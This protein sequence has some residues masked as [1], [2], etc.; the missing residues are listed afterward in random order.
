MIAAPTPTPL[1]GASPPTSRA[2]PPGAP[3]GALPFQS[4]LAEHWARTATAEGHK[5]ERSHEE[6][7]EH[8]HGHERTETAPAAVPTAATF[9]AAR[10]FG[11]LA[12][13]EAPIGHAAGVPVASTVD[14]NTA[15]AGAPSRDLL[16]GAPAA[17]V[18]AAG[19]EAAPASSGQDV[20]SAIPDAGTPAADQSNDDTA[21]SLSNSATASTL[22][23]TSTSTAS[24]PTADL[25]HASR[26]SRTT[27]DTTHSKDATPPGETRPSPGDAN[28]PTGDPHEPTGDANQPTGDTRPSSGDVNQPTGDPHEPTGDVPVPSPRHEPTGD[29]S[30]TGDVSRTGEHSTGDHSAT[31][32]V[33]R[34]GDRSATGGVWQAGGGSAAGDVAQAV[35]RGVLA[36]TSARTAAAT[37]DGVLSPST[38][39][40]ASVSTHDAP[41]TPAATGDPSTPPAPGSPGASQGQTPPAAVS[42]ASP[43]AAAARPEPG[44]AGSSNVARSGD[45]LIAAVAQPEAL[46]TRTLATSTRGASTRAGALDA[47][48]AGASSRPA[49]RASGLQ[50]FT[51]PLPAT[52]TSTAAPAATLA[53]GVGM[54]DM[55][56]SIRATIEVA[57]RQGTTRARIALQ[58]EELGEIRIHLS[59][60][61]EGLLA[62]VTADT[63]AAAQALASGRAELHHS[64]SSLGVTLLRLDIGSS[65]QS[66]IGGG[67]GRFPG[68]SDESGSGPSSRSDEKKAGSQSVP[69]LEDAQSTIGPARGELVDVLA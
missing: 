14:A 20:S 56:D 12:R 9:D 33:P 29:R 61:S 63:P 18:L 4:A 35:T 32:D 67:Q 11:V 17:A 21:R 16:A 30:P 24:T 54:Q 40:A 31:G 23:S 60:T 37:H 44:E 46:P 47:T 50:P 3:P 59:Q 15:T 68:R 51:A 7:K 10:P 42:T 45:A 66:D 58:P 38:Q 28:Q 34:T 55:I 41:A 25:E 62:R 57:I 6:H 49:D 36:N 8:E 65:G 48:L 27:V 13:T 22:H 26:A 2:A 64:L 1:P 19:D 5:P 39:S 43:G 53:A 52:Q 69:G